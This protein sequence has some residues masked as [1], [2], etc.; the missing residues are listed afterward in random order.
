MAIATPIRGHPKGVNSDRVGLKIGKLDPP[1]RFSKEVVFLCHPCATQLE[2]EHCSYYPIPFLFLVS[3][4]L[5]N[6]YYS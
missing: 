1:S 5:S 3:S 4:Q 6:V 2:L